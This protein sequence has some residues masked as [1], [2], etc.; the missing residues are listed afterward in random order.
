VT[1]E[2]RCRLRVRG[3]HLARRPPAGEVYEASVEQLDY[4]GGRSSGGGG[5]SGGSGSKEQDELA[6]ELLKV[7]CRVLLSVGCPRACG[8]LLDC[9]CLPAA[10]LPAAAA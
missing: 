3:V 1:L 6:Q 9:H 10:C 5:S 8:W 2:G 4:F 7:R